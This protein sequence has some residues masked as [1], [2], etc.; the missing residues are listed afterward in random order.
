MLTNQI[1]I[2]FLVGCSLHLAAE[3][4]PSF[5]TKDT[6]STKSW[7]YL[8]Q[9]VQQNN[10]DSLKSRIYLEGWLKKA[11]QKKNY[12]QMAQAY[13]IMS[14]RS[15]RE[16]RLHYA[17]SML[18]CAMQTS[19]NV[20]IGNAYLTKGIVHYNNR[21]LR[22]ALDNYLK[23][24]KYVAKTD[25]LDAKHMIKYTLAITKY[26]IGFYDEAIALFNECLNYYSEENDRAYLNT[27]HALALCNTN[28][29]MQIKDGV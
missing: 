3:P 1:T 4:H 12:Y 17:D 16:Q 13:R 2:L 18:T 14:Y 25:D 7:E 5:N 27:L 21:E 29:D 15:N 26:Q 28:L 23:A 11:K 22:K 19:D 6:L 24:D 20:L 8:N 10:A 9:A